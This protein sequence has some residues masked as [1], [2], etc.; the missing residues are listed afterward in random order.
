VTDI[1]LKSYLSLA[2]CTMD[3]LLR[4]T[5]EMDER[6][7]L[8]TAVRVALGTNA[9]ASTTEVLPDPDSTDRQGWWGDMDAEVIWGGW[10][11]GTKNWL[12]SRAKIT[13]AFSEEGA[14]VE[15]AR[16]YTEAALQP[17]VNKRIASRFTVTAARNGLGRIDVQAVI[18]R[19]PLA[20]IELRYQLLWEEGAAYGG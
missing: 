1:R 17:F 18:Y 6:E 20:E 14:A 16:K 12:L 3:L 11:I 10:P 4:D 5:G 13:D 8:A 9:M 15:R 19:G 2:A 7:E